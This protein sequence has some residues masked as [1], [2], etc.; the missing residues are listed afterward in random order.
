MQEEYRESSFSGEIS[1]PQV[2]SEDPEVFEFRLRPLREGMIDSGVAYLLT[3]A[4]KSYPALVR[5]IRYPQDRSP[6]LQ[7]KQRHHEEQYVTLEGITSAQANQVHQLIQR[8]EPKIL[9]F[10][11]ALMHHF[12]LPILPQGCVGIR[13]RPIRHDSL[14]NPDGVL[15]GRGMI[16]LIASSG[17]V[18]RATIRGSSRSHFDMSSHTTAWTQDLFLEGITFEQVQYIQRVTQEVGPQATTSIG[19]ILT[20]QATD[21]EPET[22]EL[23]VRM[24][25]QGLMRKSGGEAQLISRSGAIF[26]IVIHH[27]TP[28]ST[29]HV[30]PSGRSRREYLISVEGIP[31]SQA[32]E[33]QTLIQEPAQLEID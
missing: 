14:L 7:V 10:V 6:E 28:L 31:V 30:T 33:M 23:H 18:Y 4:G 11:G 1:N 17:E 29:F 20:T 25:Q 9:A 2:L 12:S 27:I 16:H 8:Q 5:A 22:I 13:V 19:S 21:G 3:E 15:L 24:L 32:E 26:S